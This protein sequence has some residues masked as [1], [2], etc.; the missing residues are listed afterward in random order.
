MPGGRQVMQRFRTVFVSFLS[1]IVCLYWVGECTVD[2]QTAN[3]DL[4]ALP[5]PTGPFDIA[6]VTLNWKDESRL[7]LLSSNHDPREIVVHI[8]Y[9]AEKDAGPPAEYLNV[10]AFEDT[11]GANRLRRE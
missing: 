7:E 1:L 2:A 8:W 9:P 4:H 11:L 10:K 3:A 5:S 6:R